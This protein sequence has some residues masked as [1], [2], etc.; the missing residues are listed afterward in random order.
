MLV[1]DVTKQEKVD[2]GGHSRQALENQGLDSTIWEPQVGKLLICIPNER[3]PFWG[4]QR[5]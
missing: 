1:S 3:V 2:C 5:L 4:L